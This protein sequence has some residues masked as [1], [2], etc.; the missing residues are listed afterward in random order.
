MKN[1]SSANEASRNSAASSIDDTVHVSVGKD[2]L[3]YRDKFEGARA[4]LAATAIDRDELI[5]SL[6]A[7]VSL[8]ENTILEL[9]RVK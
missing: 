9:T 5:A 8:L 1:R 6:L 4:Y 7:R 3:E 2:A